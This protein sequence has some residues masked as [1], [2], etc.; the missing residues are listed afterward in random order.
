M[1]YFGL[2]NLCTWTT[3]PVRTG[4]TCPREGGQELRLFCGGG[5]QG[6]VDQGH[7]R[8]RHRHQEKVRLSLAYFVYFVLS[9]PNSSSSHWNNVLI[10]LFLINKF[11]K[12][13]A[14]SE[15]I[16]SEHGR[17]ELNRS[18]NPHQERHCW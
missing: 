6:E 10:Y 12:S 5:N 7:R 13:Q 1:N 15:Q 3:W 8:H 4:T 17:L 9:T 2:I 18:Q 14:D 11:S 16:W